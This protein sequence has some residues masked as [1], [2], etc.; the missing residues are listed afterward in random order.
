V[1]WD[2]TTGEPIHNALVWQDTR[3]EPNEDIFGA[4]V[5]TAGTVLRS[6]EVDCV[7]L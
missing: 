4:R 3:N 5:S 6:P 2:R 1:V 7:G